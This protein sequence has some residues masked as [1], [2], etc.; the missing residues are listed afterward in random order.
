MPDAVLGLLVRRSYRASPESVFRAFTDPAL[1]ARWFSP[2][3]EIAVEVL[4]FELAIGGCYRLAYRL[5]EHTASTVTGVFREIVAP[6]RLVFT[7][8]WEAPD[9]HAGID[10]LVTV[11]ISDGGGSL[12]EVTVRHERFP[13]DATRDRHDEGWGTTLD[14]LPEALA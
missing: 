1:L 13:D 3:A 14:R 12:T 11:E 4:A 5:D 8:T 10:T 7:W 6:S 2:S 9:P